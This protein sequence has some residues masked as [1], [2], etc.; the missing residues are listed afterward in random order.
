MAELLTVWMA[1]EEA[2]SRSAA[3]SPI[4]PSSAVQ[5]LE[6][7][8]RGDASAFDEIVAHLHPMVFRVAIRLLGNREDAEDV[9][10]ETFWNLYRA[11]ASLRNPAC[12]Q[13]WLYRST[14]NGARSHLSRSRRR[15]ER[16]PPET[17][18]W[19]AAAPGVNVAEILLLR[20]AIEQALAELTAKEREALVLRDI[21]GLEIAEVAAAM[22]VFTVTVR[23][24]LS[25]ARLKLRQ[26]LRERGIHP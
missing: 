11:S 25:R 4:L 20:D 23:T 2:A 10:Q 19:E 7:F 24:H 22:G 16:R 18:V 3:D 17:P 8:R 12:L 14:V 15:L 6:R 13:A 5:L 21:E 9:V 26:I 1:S